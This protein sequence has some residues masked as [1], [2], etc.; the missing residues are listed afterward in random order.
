MSTDGMRRGPGPISLAAFAAIAIV[1]LVMC[2]VTSQFVSDQ[3]Q[4]L[5][6]E[7]HTAL[8]LSPRMTIGADQ[9]YAF[10][11]LA[12]A[13]SNGLHWT[14]HREAR[15]EM[16]LADMSGELKFDAAT[17]YVIVALSNYE[18]PVAE[19]AARHLAARLPGVE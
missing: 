5:L 17:G 6:D 18:A 7:R 11:F 12:A 4:R 2:L 9:G 15:F 1:A 10:G 8:L 14:G 3:E 19:H 16:D 13:D